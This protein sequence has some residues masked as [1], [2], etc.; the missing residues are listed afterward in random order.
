MIEPLASTKIYISDKQFVTVHVYKDRR[1]VIAA[2]GKDR[3]NA[4]NLLAFHGWGMATGRDG[5]FK[6]EN[7]LGE[8]HFALTGMQDLGLVAHEFMHVITR[9][10]QSRNYHRKMNK[11]DGSYVEIVANASEALH[12]GFWKWFANTFTYKNGKYVLN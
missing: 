10:I 8:V 6:R 3:P 12:R 2:W 4:K 1:G 5:K 7:D 9:F 11:L